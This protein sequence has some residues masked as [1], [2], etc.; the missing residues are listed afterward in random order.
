MKMDIAFGQYCHGESV[1]HRLDPRVKILTA[2]L[3]IVEIFLA[4][5]VA[6]FALIVAATVILIALSGISPR[7]ILRGIRP[8]VFVILF[9]AI[10]NIFFVRGEKPLLEF[11]FIKI[12]PEGLINAAFI[13]LRIIVLIVSTSLFL[14]Y[15]TTPIALTD[16]LERLLSPLSKIRL[17][18]HEFS[19]MMTIALRFIP[20]LIEETEKIM[21]AQK[22]RGADFS[23]G[24]LIKRSKALI[25]IMIPLFVSAFRR[26]DELATAMECRCYTG[27]KGRT[28]MN[29][30]KA[31]GRDLVFA[32]CIVLLGAVV[33]L[34]NIY[35]PY[36]RVG[37]Y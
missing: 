17:P 27:G 36:L 3:F 21:N 14:T 9:T 29:V 5:S 7:I 1:L 8:I 28:R 2:I 16:G 18:V 31:G 34:L 4:K 24:G 35:V 15:T 37:M 20:T 12:Y 10:I 26:A 13:A 19:M 25:P 11:Y 33:V 6:A 22:A 23:T 30:L 32:L